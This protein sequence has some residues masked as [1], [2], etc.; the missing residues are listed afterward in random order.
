MV[1]EFPTSNPETL[2]EGGR[3]MIED[4]ANSLPET[5]SAEELMQ[6]MQSGALIKKMLQIG[7]ELAQK[8]PDL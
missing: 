4:Y 2:K 3:K 6:L 5:M 8:K 7:E 1:K